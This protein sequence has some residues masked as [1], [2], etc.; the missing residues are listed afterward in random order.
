MPAMT[1]EVTPLEIFL[2]AEV[3]LKAIATFPCCNI[4]VKKF[5]KKLIAILER[6]CSANLNEII[7]ILLVQS[8]LEKRL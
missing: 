2:L 3:L 8:N 6:R 4:G 7:T 1:V 5:A